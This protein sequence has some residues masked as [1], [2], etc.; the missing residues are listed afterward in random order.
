MD[1]KQRLVQKYLGSLEDKKQ[2]LETLYHSAVNS[3]A[4]HD[5]LYQALHK[6]AGSAGMYG[7]DQISE[8][9]SQ[10]LDD[11]DSESLPGAGVFD[12]RFASLIKLLSEQDS[13]P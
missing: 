3:T 5:D 9:A 10:L 1:P 4:G 7:F 6:L 8:S 13:H 12:E 2:T 11:L